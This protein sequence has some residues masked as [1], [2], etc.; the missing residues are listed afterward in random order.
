MVIWPC[1]LSFVLFSILF[2]K[3][4]CFLIVIATGVN[5]CVYI[6]VHVYFS[7]TIIFI[8]F[9]NALQNG[10]YLSWIYDKNVDWTNR[11][12]GPGE[13]CLVQIGRPFWKYI[14]DIPNRGVK[15]RWQYE[16][17]P[18]VR[19][20]TFGTYFQNKNKEDIEQWM[21]APDSEV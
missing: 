17:Q 11:L 13:K 6:Y 16:N 19:N 2:L 9:V 1:P 4:K 20:R 5:F 21:T 12:I 3:L 7:Q 18:A 8:S 14:E 10:S 15:T